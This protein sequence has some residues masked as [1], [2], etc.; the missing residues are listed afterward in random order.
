MV[1]RGTGVARSPPQKYHTRTVDNATSAR[2]VAAAPSRAPLGLI[3][4]GEA[5]ALELLE[6]YL[7]PLATAAGVLLFVCGVALLRLSWLG[8]R[9]GNVPY[10][11]SGWMLI[12]GAFWAFF[13]AWDVEVGVAYGLIVLALAAYG[14]IILRREIRVPKVQR[15]RE[16]ALEPEERP[17]NWPRAIA[18]ALL[19]IVL[20]G[21]AAIGVGVAF[22]VAMPLATHDRIVVGGLLVPVL[23]GAG[24]AWTLSDSKLLRAT[25]LLVGISAVGYAVAFLPKVL[26]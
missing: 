13:R 18:K 15:A 20:A 19:S 25:L 4:T 5:R 22:A 7:V 26:A 23:W 9:P 8:K 2:I 12:A 21:I 24:M 1:V 10:L 3:F 17:T 16:A 14:I 6:T 11:I